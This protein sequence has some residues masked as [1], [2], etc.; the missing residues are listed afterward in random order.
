MIDVVPDSR[1]KDRSKGAVWSAELQEWMQ[2]VACINCG[3]SGGFVTEK[4]RHFFY[5]C[6][7]CD[8]KHGPIAGMSAI[9]DAEFFAALH[10]ASM[11]EHGRDLT[12]PELY[13]VA[14]RNAT[15][16]ARLINEGRHKGILQ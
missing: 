14:E 9:P 3:A 16:L 11:E 12:G 7:R 8:E 6:P 5:V 15:P 13:A 2:P 1:L 10:E 4:T